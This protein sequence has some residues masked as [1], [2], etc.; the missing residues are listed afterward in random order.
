M[1][2]R[3]AGDT[4]Q[5]LRLEQE[6]GRPY[7]YVSGFVDNF[8]NIVSVKDP[9]NPKTL[10]HWQIDNS[11]LH[12]G[13]GFLRG[14]PFKV[15]GRYYYAQCMQFIGSG[16]ILISVIIFDVTGLP[17]AKLVKEVARVRYPQALGGFHD[18]VA[19]KHS[20]GRVL[21][22]TLAATNHGNIYDAEKIVSGADPKTWQ[23]AEI[24][25]PGNPIINSIVGAYHDFFIGYDPAV[26]KD[27]LY[28]AGAGGYYVFDVTKPETPQL[29]SR[30][31]ARPASRTGTRSHPP[32]TESLPWQTEY[33]VLP[34]RIFDLRPALEGRTQKST[35]RSQ[36]GRPTGR[37]S[38]TTTKSA[39][40]TCSHWPTKTVYRSST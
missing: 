4:R 17:D 37:T 28:G 2:H 7:V 36:R 8:F 31:P 13:L 11:A 3:A 35:G 24:P 29:S 33:R 23:I 12:G 25:V 10:F 39:G 9:S 5:T 21:L 27:K 6:M 18:V 20:D 16:P 1:L 38:C 30:L 15:K 40:H 34:P 22:F 32:P 19:Y 26:G 14:V